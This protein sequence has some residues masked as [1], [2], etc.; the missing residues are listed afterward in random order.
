MK[1]ETR[2]CRVRLINYI[3]RNKVVLDYKFIVSISRL[4][5]F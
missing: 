1:A 5:N 2:S 3:L 4:T